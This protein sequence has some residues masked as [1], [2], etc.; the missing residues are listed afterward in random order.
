[1]RRR[2]AGHR[3]ESRARGL[4]GR[5]RTEGR[6]PPTCPPAPLRPP[7]TA[8]DRGRSRACPH[9]PRPGHPP[10]PRGPEP[11]ALP[12]GAAGAWICYRLSVNEGPCLRP[13]RRLS[14]R[15]AA[16]DVLSP[17]SE[18]PP[19]PAAELN[20][21]HVFGSSA[22]SCGRRPSGRRRNTAVTWKEVP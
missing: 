2:G 11:G 8:P 17:R 10:A 21:T 5:G 19:S 20:W 13:P 6:A 16:P 4:C 14:S 7:P 18:L 3:P 15:A 12:A 9:W 1:M 22:R